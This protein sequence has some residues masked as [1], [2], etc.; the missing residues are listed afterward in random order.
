[1]RHID[2]NEPVWGSSSL[3]LTYKLTP[4]KRH[5]DLQ[6]DR[7]TQTDKLT[8]VR[9]DG[10]THRSLES[11]DIDMFSTNCRQGKK[12]AEQSVH[13]ALTFKT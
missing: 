9:E 2:I 13:F 5:T 10:V 8:A 11:P 4:T 6:R 3:C 12:Y 1:M 7:Q